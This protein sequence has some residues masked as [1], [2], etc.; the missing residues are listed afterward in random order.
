MTTPSPT[1]PPAQP[2]RTVAVHSTTLVA[3]SVV[4]VALI[5]AGVALALAHWDAGAIAGLLT[6]IIGVAAVALGQ[7]D[8]LAKSRHEQAQNTATLAV[9]D[10]RTNGELDAR[11]ASA[12]TAA[13]NTLP[14]PVVAPTANP[15]PPAPVATDTITPETLAA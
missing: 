13:L 1:P 4:L 12:V 11:I 15:S 10:K 3:A 9:I 8:Q 5:G 14:A 7:L 2:P 6:A